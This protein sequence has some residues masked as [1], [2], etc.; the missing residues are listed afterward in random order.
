MKISEVLSHL[1]NQKPSLE[2][3][4]RRHGTDKYQHGFLPFYGKFF[5]PLREEPIRLL[6]VGIFGGGSLRMWSEYF[7][8]ATIVGCDIKT[9]TFVTGPRISC[10]QLD[11]SSRESLDG[12]AKMHP[13]GF[14][15]IIDDGSH[16]VEHQQLT[17]A[18][19]FPLLRDGGMYV[20][21]DLH[22]SVGKSPKCFE[23]YG[24]DASMANSTFRILQRFMQDRIFESPYLSPEEHGYINQNLESCEILVSKKWSVTSLLKKGSMAKP[25]S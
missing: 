7:E 19:L 9:E 10:E 21:E 1:L 3:L 25:T 4:G 18:K 14:D 2:S 20:I 11:Q 12:F 24:L 6:E 23:Q 22:T 13:H 15:I 16:V 17:F 8:K 5:S